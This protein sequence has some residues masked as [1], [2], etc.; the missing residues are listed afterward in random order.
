MPL[1]A[2]VKAEDYT[3][4]DGTQLRL[5]D[6]D[7]GSEQYRSSDYYEW[8]AES[9]GSQ[10]L[11]IFPTR[12]NLTT[13]TLHYYSNNHRGLPRLRFWS[14]PDDFDVWDALSATYSRVDIAA[15]T[16]GGE[17]AGLW[18]VSVNVNFT[19]KRIL[20]FKFSSSIILAVGEVE[21]FTQCVIN[22]P[23]SKCSDHS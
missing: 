3:H 6:S 23:Y 13:I 12:V 7:L 17:P 1:A 22:Y 16:P 11:F 8:T 15:V 20:M 2:S 19:T 21:F 18:N 4:C 9:S 5:T 14:V 10:L